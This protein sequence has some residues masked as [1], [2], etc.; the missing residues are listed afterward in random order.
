MDRLKDNWGEVEHRQIGIK[1]Y[2]FELAFS[3]GGCKNKGDVLSL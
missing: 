2:F 1:S 3:L